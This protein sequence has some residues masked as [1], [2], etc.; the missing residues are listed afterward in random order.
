MGLISIG[1]LLLVVDF[2]RARIGSE[3]ER[4]ASQLNGLLRA[5]L[6]NAMLKRDLPGLEAIVSDLAGVPGVVAV[7]IVNPSLEVRFA[8]DPADKDMVLDAPALRSAAAG[9]ATG[10]VVFPVGPDGSSFAP[11]LPSR[12]NRNAGNAMASPRK[13]RSTGFWSWTTKRAVL[14]KRRAAVRCCFSPWGSW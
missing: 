14:D 9:E 11:S 5:S 7:R 1:L 6:E 2:Y 13:T 4:A 3:Q 10:T 12:T 8:S